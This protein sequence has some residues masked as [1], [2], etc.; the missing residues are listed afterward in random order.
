M[1]KVLWEHRMERLKVLKPKGQLE[2]VR[3]S[4]LYCFGGKE[5]YGQRS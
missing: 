1:D 5:P 3:S 4:G 2:I